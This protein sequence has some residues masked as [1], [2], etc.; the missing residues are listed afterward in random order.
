MPLASKLMIELVGAC[1]SSQCHRALRTGIG[2]LAPLAIGSALMVMVYMGGHVSG[3]HYNPAV[4]FGLFLRS[5]IDAPTII[6]R[7]TQLVAGVL[8]FTFSGTL[9]QW[10]Y[11][12]YPSWAPCLLVLGAGR[13]DRF[14]ISAGACGAQRGSD[15][16]HGGQLL[17]WAGHRVY[18]RDRR[19]CRW[20]H[21]RS[22]VQP[23]RR[24]RRHIWRRGL[25]PKLMVRSLALHRGSARRCGHCSGCPIQPHALDSGGTGEV[26]EY[27]RGC[28][29]DRGLRCVRVG[30]SAAD[31][32]RRAGPIWLS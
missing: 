28:L 3:A 9:G 16:G 21:L 22:C 14:H 24:G 5:A 20:A 13:R 19:L 6:Y 18:C 27:G 4:S 10:S 26:R 25:R 2:P 7:I 17:L 32:Q 8:A 15:Q 11:P 23:G 12:R 1:S 30:T 31:T 29:R